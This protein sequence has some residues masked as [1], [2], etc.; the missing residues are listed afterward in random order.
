MEPHAI[1]GLI[2]LAIAIGTFLKV[3]GN[4][5]KAVLLI[6]LIM[7]GST[8]FIGGTPELGSLPLIGGFFP[9]VDL[10]AGGLLN[11]AK[12]VAWSVDIVGA[13]K[14]SEGTLALLVANTG[15]FDVKELS[16]EVNGQGVAITNS[17]KLPLAKGETT[18]VDTDFQGEGEI[19]IKV[20]A[21]KAEKTFSTSI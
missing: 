17:P 18:L 8:L 1:I 21:G 14:D 4:I 16:I 19:E 20:T 11:M 12:G 7:I 13:G 9:Q 2:I 3:I 10:S 15:E 5:V 6:G